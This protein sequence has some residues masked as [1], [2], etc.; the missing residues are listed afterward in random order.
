[1]LIIQKLLSIGTAF[2]YR[3]LLYIHILYYK[4]INTTYTYFIL[5]IF[6]YDY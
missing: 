5:Y 4:N 6:L 3:Q 1:M 2:Y